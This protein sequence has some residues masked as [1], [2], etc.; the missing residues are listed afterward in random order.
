MEQ[1]IL[2]FFLVSNKCVYKCFSLICFFSN[3]CIFDVFPFLIISLLSLSLDVNNL[4]Q[5]SYSIHHLKCHKLFKL[6]LPIITHH[7]HISW[8]LDRCTETYARVC[9]CKNLYFQNKIM[10]RFLAEFQQN[11][12]VILRSCGK[13]WTEIA[14][15]L[16][17]KYNK[18]VTKRGMQYLWKKFGL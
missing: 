18:I 17:A 14:R 15:K 10:D 11:L 8:L 13:S 4:I 12:I 7:I 5:F 1:I 6:I 3:S 16:R 9:I 2:I